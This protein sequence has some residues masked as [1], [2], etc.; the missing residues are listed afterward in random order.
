MLKEVREVPPC[1]GIFLKMNGEA[2]AICLVEIFQTSA[3]GLF[4]SRRKGDEMS[5]R[6]PVGC[7]K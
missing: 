6:I 4:R 2:T 1:I 7:F 5:D 3:G